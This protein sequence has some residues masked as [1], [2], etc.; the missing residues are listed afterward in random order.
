M[1]AMRNGHYAKV[2]C[3]L[4]PVEML[5]K[6][7]ALISDKER[8]TQGAYSRTVYT[9]DGSF[10]CFCSVGAIRQACRASASKEVYDDSVLVSRQLCLEALHNAIPK[11]SLHNPP[12][13]YSPDAVALYNDGK[14]RTHKQIMALYDRAL[15]LLEAHD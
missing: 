2:R 13:K 6:A 5:L 3:N 8:W 15:K 9:N 12:A 1:R 7:K 14:K 11:R 10:Q 4:K